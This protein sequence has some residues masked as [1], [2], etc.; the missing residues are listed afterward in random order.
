MLTLWPLRRTFTQYVFAFSKT[1]VSCSKSLLS[2]DHG[3]DSIVHVL[4]EVNLGTSESTL[5]GDVKDAV[6]GLSVL[7]VSTSDVNEVLVGNGVELLLVSSE[8]GELD[9]TEARIPVPRLVGQEVIYPRWSSLANLAT[10]SI[11]D[12]AIESLS[13]TWRMFDPFCMEMIRS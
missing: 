7:S 9:V 6:V 12:E 4:D 5:V 13:K 3:L 8:L 11:L 1:L 2:G 10:A